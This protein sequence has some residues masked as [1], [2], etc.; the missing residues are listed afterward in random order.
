MVPPIVVGAHPKRHEP[1]PLE[2]AVKFSC[3]TGAPLDVVGSYWFDTTPHR[4][5]SDEYAETLAREARQSLEREVGDPNRAAA[6]IRFHVQ[7]GSAAHAMKQTASEVG[8]G[9]MVVGSSHRGTLGRIALGSTADRV[10]EGAPCPVAVAPRGFV[11]DGRPPERIGVAFV[12]TPGGRSALRA[13][14]AI[15]RRTGARLIAYT[16]VESHADESDREGAA[17]AVQRVVA[18]HA[19]HIDAEARLLTDKGVDALVR[20][21]HELDILVRGSRAHAPV[22]PPLAMGLPSRLARQVA[23]PFV[24]VAPGREDPLV[25]LFGSRREE[26]LSA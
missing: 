21:S 24:I 8:A 22:R 4:T 19:A 16:V 12:D 7:S 14:A 6:E 18:E 15:A 9:L 26:A 13:G 3:L 23:C 2:L 10:V 11:D 20:A 25:E 1:E 17:S 5:A